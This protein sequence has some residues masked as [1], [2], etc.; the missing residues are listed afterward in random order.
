[1]AVCRKG[2]AWV[3][4][5]GLIIGVLIVVNIL[6]LLNVILSHTDYVL[7]C[8]LSLPIKCAPGWVK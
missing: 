2:G 7:P 6:Y 5:T 3:A 1:M 8:D 4:A